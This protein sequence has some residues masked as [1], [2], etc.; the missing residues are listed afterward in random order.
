M[1]LKLED[2]GIEDEHVDLPP[3]RSEFRRLVFNYFE[4]ERMEN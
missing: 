3:I 1:R 2:G 4:L